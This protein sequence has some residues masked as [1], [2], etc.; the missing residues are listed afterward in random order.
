MH[1]TVAIIGGGPSGLL[2][3]YLLHVQ[4]IDNLVLEHRSRRYVESRVRAGQLDHASVSFL[5]EV[6]LGDRI[7]REGMPQMGMNVRFG[8]ETHH[9]DLEAQTEGCH[10]MIYGQSELTKDLIA[11]L[12]DRGLSPTF[13]AQNVSVSDPTR[14]KVTITYDLHG[15]PG[16]LSADIV[17]GCDGAHGPCRKVVLASTSGASKALPFAWMGLLSETLP[18]SEELTYV[19]HN[20]GFALWSMRKRTISRTYL[21]CATEDRLEDWSEDRFWSEMAARLGEAG[22][23]IAPGRTLERVKVPMQAFVA[24]RI[25]HG[26]LILAGDAAHIVPP[27][28]AKGLNL[29]ISDISAL[30]AALTARLTQSDSTALDRYESAAHQRAWAEQHF[31]WQMTDL[32]H[33]SPVPDQF[34]DQFKITHLSNLLS[35]PDRLRPFCERYVGTKAIQV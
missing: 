16:R 30:S 4:G 32:F 5:D 31:S 13:E 22:Q 10:C 15:A 35:S 28:A 7:M 8:E 6:G 20:R 12:V 27:S 26:N 11:N 34:D 17:I 24:H 2:L 14:D 19:Y 3:S 29:A 21:Q 1:T 23:N 18:I 25:R 33:A 9:I